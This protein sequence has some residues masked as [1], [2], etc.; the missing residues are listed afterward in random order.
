[1]AK[2]KS[3]IT[4]PSKD[5]LESVMMTIMNLMLIGVTADQIMAA[6]KPLAEEAVKAGK[7]K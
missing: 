5:G 3:A 2:R 6:L 1:M 7:L 4:I